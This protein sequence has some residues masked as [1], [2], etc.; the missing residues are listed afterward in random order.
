MY[1]ILVRVVYQPVVGFVIRV[2]LP[3]CRTSRVGEISAGVVMG[4]SLVPGEPIA[5]SWWLDNPVRD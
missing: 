5:V 1:P 3:D 4:Y 2:R